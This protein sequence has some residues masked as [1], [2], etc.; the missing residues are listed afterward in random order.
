M[1]ESN[2]CLFHETEVRLTVGRF[3]GIDTVCLNEPSSSHSGGDVVAEA[4]DLRKSSC[5]L[6][7]QSHDLVFLDGALTMSPVAV[8]H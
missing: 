8:K 7:K 2:K 4:T 5:F 1:R 6:S 3:Q